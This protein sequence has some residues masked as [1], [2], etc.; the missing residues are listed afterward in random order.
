MI[1]VWVGI[2]FFAGVGLYIVMPW[3]A[4]KIAG[5]DWVD[6]VAQ[7]YV[8][9]AQSAARKSA[10]VERDGVLE[11]VSKRYD[12]DIKGDKD[13]KHDTRH[14]QDGFDVLSRMSNKSFGLALSDRSEYVSPLLAELGERFWRAREEGEIGEVVQTKNGAEC[15]KDGVI[16]DDRSKMVDLG[17]AR[18]A[19]TGSADPESGHESYINTQISQEK[20]NQKLSTGQTFMIILGLVGSFVATVMA[21]NYTGGESAEATSPSQN[22]TTLSYLA[23]L[24]SAA[25]GKTIG[26]KTGAVIY[27]LGWVL[28]VPVMAGLFVGPVMAV[29]LA[30]LTYSVAGFIPFTIGLMG[31]SI[32]AALGII[33]ARGHWIL[34][35]LTTGG[36]CITRRETGEYEYTRLERAPDSVEEQRELFGDEIEDEDDL[37]DFFVR[38]VDGTVLGVD[39]SEG[40]LYRFAWAPLG[41]TEEKGEEN[42]GPITDQPPANVATDGGTNQRIRTKNKRMGYHALLPT[43]D[44]DEWIVPGPQFYGWC[45]N[46]AESGP[47]EEGRDKALR[48]HGGEQQLGAKWFMICVLLA[49]VMG[50]AMGMVAG[51]GI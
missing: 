34:A 8:W 28:L 30:L 11:L 21:L 14:H 42:M 5:D 9:L 47:V 20:F 38:L 33:M 32:P 26:R 3:T 10:I 24:I 15:M 49:T 19:T 29:L 4:A 36:G 31:P 44:E 39:G 1:L 27:A 17:R 51:G 25:G 18:H 16:V 35:Q 22:T 50:T 13:S 12:P 48:D 2:A 23:A 46:T 41:I 37:Y 43:P 6:A 7:K 45:R 40:D